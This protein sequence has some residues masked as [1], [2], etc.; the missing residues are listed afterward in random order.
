MVRVFTNW[1]TRV[2]HGR[3]PSVRL[4]CLS[5]ALLLIRV[6]P[7]SGQEVLAGRLGRLDSSSVVRVRLP[8][9]RSLTGRFVGIGDGRLGVRAESGRIDTLSLGDVGTVAVRGRHT[10]TGAIVGGTVGLAAGILAGWFVGALCDAAVC[11]RVQPF[12]ATI[13]LFAG[14]GTLLGAAIGSAVPKWSLVFP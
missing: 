3:V 7:V 10:K 13:P 11:D 12:L 8:E 9:G 4:Q 14:G 2:L 1:E 5:I 6:L